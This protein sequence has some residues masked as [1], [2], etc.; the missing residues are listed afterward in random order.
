MTG[1]ARIVLTLAVFG[2]M[3]TLMVVR[4]RRWNAAWWT[5]LAAAAM[6]ALGLVA[7][8]EALGAILAGKN[9][10]LFLL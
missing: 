2:A 7:P 9:T 10:L 5:M 8:R 3:L 1:T 4:P 6:L